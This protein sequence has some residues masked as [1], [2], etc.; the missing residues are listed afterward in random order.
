M[1]TS[2]FV[3]RTARRDYGYCWYG[4]TVYTVGNLDEI[5]PE[6]EFAVY[7]QD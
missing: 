3:E 6:E 4:E 1:N 2:D 5:G 7:G